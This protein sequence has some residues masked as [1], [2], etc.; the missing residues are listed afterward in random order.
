[1]AILGDL[2]TTQILQFAVSVPFGY[3]LLIAVYRRYFHPLAKYPGPFLASIT[4]WWMVTEI[5]SGKHEEHI[6]E[7]HK[8]LGPIVRIAPNEVA[9][10][11]PQAV[12]VIYSTG[13][14]FTKGILVPTFLLLLE[15]DGRGLVYGMANG[16]TGSLLRAR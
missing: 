13:G 1:M 12:K 10:S 11:D 4:R 15:A 14:G 8:K 7:L 2:T 3:F 16:G 5:W 6:R 9:I